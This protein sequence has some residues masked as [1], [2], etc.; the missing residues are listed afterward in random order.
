MTQQNQT[1]SLLRIALLFLCVLSLPSTLSTKELLGNY[2]SRKN[3]G[4]SIIILS[5]QGQRLRITPYGKYILR[6]QAVRF[7]E[8]Y[9]SDEHY[10]MVESHRWSGSLKLSEDSLAVT[11]KTD[12][13]DG[14][15]VRIEKNGLRISFAEIGSAS[16]F[17]RHSDGI[18]WD[19]DTI[20]TSFV[21]DENEHFT[22]LGHGYYGREKK[23]DLRGEVVQRNYGTLHGQ[24]APLIVPFYLSNK[25]YGVFLNSTFTNCFN[26]G[27]RG[28]YEFSITGEG[29]MDYFV[30]LG[31]EFRNIL[32][33]YTQLT[34][35]P[36]MLPKAALGLALSDKG[37]DHNSKDPSDEKWWKKKI[38]AH[39][40]AGFPLD[41]IVND[42]RWR[43]GGGQR[44]LSYFDWDLARY[45]DPKEYEQWVRK[46]GLIL[47]LDFNRCIAS[48]SEGWHPSFNIPEPDSIDF[49]D[50]APDIT[51]LEVREWFWKT[52]W[53]K[54][55]NPSLQFPGDALWIDEFDEMGK[56]PM[57]MVMGN[58][59]T[60]RE[61]RNYWFFLIAKALVQDGWDKSFQG[62]KRPFVW[63]RGMTSGGQRYATLWSGD[64]KPSYEDMKSQ[65]RG[66]QFAGLAGFP[67]W[68]HDA[69][70][71]NNWEENHG[72]NDMMYRQ[73]SMAFGSF[74][75]F[76]KPHGIGQSRWPLDRPKEVQR[77]SKLYSE[78]RYKMIP[79]I[80]T[81][82]HQAYET[83][84]PIARAMV[85]D[86]QN[87][88]LAWTHDLQY[89]WGDELLVAP[90]CSDSGDVEVWLPGGSWY[91]FW[92]DSSITGNQILNY[93]APTGKLPLF[94]KA[95]SIIPMGNYALSTAFLS[96]DSLTI[97]VYTGSDASFSLYEDD[98]VSERYRI[99]EGHRTSDIQFSQSIF[100]LSVGAAVGTFAGAPDQRALQIEFHGVHKKQCFTV[101]G[102]KLKMYTSERAVKKAKEGVVWNERANTL[103]VF[104]KKT[105]VKESVVISSINDCQ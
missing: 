76:W 92:N 51:K 84:M 73:W 30:I 94:V 24:Q 80:Y 27:Q 26:F 88:S 2:T 82:A 93:K 3:D 23:I 11:V 65:V 25:G 37:N 70:G 60:W 45:P 48:H 19:G 12:S 79:Y 52:F 20:H 33:R 66:L 99:N 54:S 81:Y 47:T 101:N 59:K 29:R 42:N 13:T 91:N 58:G 38:T 44:C 35:R 71:F 85:I 68:G 61:M 75:P 77:D 63:V 49:N 18:W 46:N 67:F 4:R 34:G 98:G 32:D 96:K 86:H 64:I 14:L 43:A 74:T 56:A 50:S 10:E 55:L 31:S 1:H 40:K 105:F 87:D 103:T 62:E 100:S 39:R 102:R 89:M 41:H 16:D 97:H 36:R 22:G 7:N 9:F 95:G 57:T 78:L 28:R 72:P 69:G 53:N 17:L 8:E 83:G 21:N 90:N 15:S 104:L 6:V 5:D